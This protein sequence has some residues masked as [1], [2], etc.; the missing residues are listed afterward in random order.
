MSILTRVIL[1]AL[2]PAASLAFRVKFNV[3]TAS[4]AGSFVIKVHEEWAPI[5]ATHFKKLVV[6]KHFDDTR[7]FRVIPSFMVQFGISGDPAVSAIASKD[8]INDEPVKVMIQ[9]RLKYV[10]IKSP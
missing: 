10:S 1:M 4:G 7:F 5:G 9:R 2:L 6:N 8:T 3:E